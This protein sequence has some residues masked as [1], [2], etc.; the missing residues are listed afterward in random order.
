MGLKYERL[1]G[2]CKLLQDMSGNRLAPNKAVVGENSFG[3]EAGM[4][5]AGW[6]E[7]VF[8]AEPYLPELVGQT[9]KLILGKKSGKDSVEEKLKTLGMA[10]SPEQVEKLLLKV[11][12]HAEKTKSP[13]SDEQFKEFTKEILGK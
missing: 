8:T 5:V 6:K 7:M 4:V 12:T 9:H 3:Q 10:A 2:I 13:V 1:Y 11:K